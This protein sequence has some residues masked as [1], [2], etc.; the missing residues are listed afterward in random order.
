MDG[1]DT[2]YGARLF[3]LALGLILSGAGLL[4]SCKPY[5]KGVLNE[6]LTESPSRQATV[7][8]N[9]PVLKAHMDDG[10]VYVLRDW[11][12][13]SGLVRGSGVK[14]DSEREVDNRGLY[15]I[16]VEDVALFE[17]NVLKPSGGIIAMTVI[18][19]LSVGLTGLCIS[20]PKSCFG[21]CPT[22]YAG[23]GSV[24][25]R[26]PM[27]EGF[28]SAVAPS[29]ERT[30][31]DALPE[32]RP[33]GERAV[34]RMT[35]EA[36]ETHVVRDV[37]LLAAERPDRDGGRVYRTSDEDYR[38]TYGS[39][40]PESCDAPDG[41]CLEAVR[42]R[43][44]D[45]WSSEADPEYLA[46]RETVEVGY[47]VPEQT[48]VGVAV[49]F[50][51]SFLTTFLFYRFLSDLGTKAVEFFAGLERSEG[52]AAASFEGIS[53]LMGKIEV[54]VRRDGAWKSVGG[55]HE[56]GPLADDTRLIEV[57]E[58]V[59]GTVRFRLRLAKGN[60]RIDAVRLV[61]LGPLVET[62]EL[63]L[64]SV[65]YDGEHPDQAPE[66]PGAVARDDS[67]P[68]ATRPGDAYEFA[69]ELP[70]QPDEY[71]YFLVSRGYYLEWMRETWLEEEHPERALE[72]L[73]WPERA[74]RRLAP[75]F[76]EREP[77]IEEIFWESRYVPGE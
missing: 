18:S 56:V 58:P 44:G 72:M 32:F 16:P 35:N 29:L 36:M 1:S 65:R 7:D 21:S 14:Y 76:K 45:H 67:Q 59:D 55:L 2:P 27:A 5:Q 48:R 41:D 4:G 70:E 60:W 42:E 30:D 23:R 26:R 37:R 47:R 61:E 10:D 53:E 57:P 34:L 24:A 71:E 28:S 74:L 51:Q 52:S 9:A 8:G 77:E 69:F 13:K 15:E 49:T 31:V 17:T 43:D 11:K 3:A 20:S 22:F 50:R 73:L 63:E 68:L 12:V 75:A 54:Q 62:E 46:A 33:S 64:E 38:R 40:T 39:W 6:E 19:G 66:E 25:D